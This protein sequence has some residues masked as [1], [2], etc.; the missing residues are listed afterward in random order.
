MCSRAPGSLPRLLRGPCRL[1]APPRGPHLPPQDPHHLPPDLRPLHPVSGLQHRKCVISSFL[2]LLRSS[3]SCSESEHR[4]V[5]PSPS[6]FSADQG[7]GAGEK[8]GC[9]RAPGDSCPRSSLRSSH[10][11][12]IPKFHKAELV[13]TPSRSCALGLVGGG[14]DPE[15]TDL[16]RAACMSV[17]G[18]DPKPALRTKFTGAH[19][20]GSESDLA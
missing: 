6:Q 4:L 2:S 14:R 18:L 1:R 10:L 16:S 15:R 19:H 17:S 8:C 5:F 7:P 20:P 9:S 3:S 13:L 11:T 12:E